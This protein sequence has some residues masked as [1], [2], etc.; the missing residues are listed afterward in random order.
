[1]QHKHEIRTEINKQT[2]EIQ[3]I[4][5]NTD[6][7]TVLTVACLFLT[8]VLKCH[9]TSAVFLRKSSYDM[10]E[11]SYYEVMLF[12][13]ILDYFVRSISCRITGNT[14]TKHLAPLN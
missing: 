9:I 14:L 12:I 2:A 13:N 10:N 1:M 6:Y 4:Q 8:L 7:K 11:L 3:S 5:C